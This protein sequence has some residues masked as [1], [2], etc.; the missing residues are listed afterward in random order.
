MLTCDRG[1][2]FRAIS[3]QEVCDRYN[4]EL[5]LKD[6]EDLNGLA[7]MDNAIAHIKKA[8]RRLQEIEGGDWL[9]H[10]AHATSAF[11]K[12]HHGATGAPPCNI[13]TGP[14]GAQERVRLGVY[15]SFCS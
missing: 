4:V 1:P 6:P 5:E 14:G 2:E 7:R 10:I 8:T 15:V 9:T 12:T 11:N 13:R 3:F